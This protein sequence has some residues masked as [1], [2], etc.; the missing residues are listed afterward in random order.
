MWIIASVDKKLHVKDEKLH[1]SAKIMSYTKA[2][3]KT[4]SLVLC[5]METIIQ[6]K[7]KSAI[8]RGFHNCWYNI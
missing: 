5:F 6:N 7:S 2:T 4:V 1:V 3:Q 8:I